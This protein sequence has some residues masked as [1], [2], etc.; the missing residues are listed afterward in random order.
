MNDKKLT[1]VKRYYLGEMSYVNKGANLL[2]FNFF[3]RL[4]EGGDNIMAEK[5]DNTKENAQEVKDTPKPE[6]LMPEDF[7]TQ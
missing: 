6:N 7:I 4:K 5:K 2:E 3:K 1:K